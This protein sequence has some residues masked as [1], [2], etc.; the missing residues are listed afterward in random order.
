MAGLL[1][2]N[3]KTQTFTLLNKLKNITILL[4]KVNI[5]GYINQKR[6]EN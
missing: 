4:F 3:K 6:I 1:N 5:A 2:S